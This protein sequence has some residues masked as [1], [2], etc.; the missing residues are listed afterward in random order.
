VGERSL[1]T[2]EVAGS[3]PAVPIANSL[4]EQGAAADLPLRRLRVPLAIEDPLSN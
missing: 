2:R 1:H 4:Q 3:S